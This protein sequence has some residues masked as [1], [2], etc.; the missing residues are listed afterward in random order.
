MK[1]EEFFSIYVFGGFLTA[2]TGSLWAEFTWSFE[3]ILA[4]AVLWP[5]V[6]LKA[7]LKG[8]KEL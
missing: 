1:L 6:L 4:S 2:M 8:I 7:F 3:K 5:L